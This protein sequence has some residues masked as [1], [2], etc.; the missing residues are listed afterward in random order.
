MECVVR[1][2]E[3]GRLWAINDIGRCDGMWLLDPVFMAVSEILTS[4]DDL[5]VVFLVLPIYLC[6]LR[7]GSKFALFN[8]C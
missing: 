2:D 1:S 4:K 7:F 6:M 8:R 3:A 5:S